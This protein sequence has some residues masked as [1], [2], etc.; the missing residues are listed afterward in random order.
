MDRGHSPQ[1][2]G[3]KLYKSPQAVQKKSLSDWKKGKYGRELLEEHGQVLFREGPPIRQVYLSTADCVE[4]EKKGN[5]STLLRRRPTSIQQ[6]K[7]KEFFRADHLQKGKLL[8][9]KMIE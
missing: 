1:P 4:K 7:D 2:R 8:D 5:R 9:K 3:G 6:R